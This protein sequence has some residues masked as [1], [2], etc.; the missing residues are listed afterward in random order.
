VKMRD[1]KG[2]CFN[3]NTGRNLEAVATPL[4]REILSSI[5]CN[6]TTRSLQRQTPCKT[7]YMSDHPL[8][9]TGYKIYFKNRT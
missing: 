1:V 3:L 8:V 6:P 2:L 7:H 5:R 4:T 9:A